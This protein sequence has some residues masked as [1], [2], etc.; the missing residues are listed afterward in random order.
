ML[1][2]DHEGLPR[3]IERAIEEVDDGYAMNNLA[4]LLQSGS[5]HRCDG[6]GQDVHRTVKLFERAA[7]EGNEM[8]TWNLVFAL[9]YGENGIPRDTAR[10]AQLL[11]DLVD[12]GGDAAMVR[13]AGIL[14][15]D[16][17]GFESDRAEA[18]TSYRQAINAG[19]P[20]A[21]D[22]LKVFLDGDGSGVAEKIAR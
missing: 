12:K 7:A 18:V 2:N 19:H 15:K 1:E 6:V 5:P 9:H 21:Q 20:D 11:Q 16:A 13:L 10:A 8:A 3:G 17:E 14:E 22:I 4:L